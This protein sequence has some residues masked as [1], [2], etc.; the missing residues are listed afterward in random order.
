MKKRGE[1]VPLHRAMLRFSG[2]GNEG[3]LTMRGD[4]AGETSS[5]FIDGIES[6]LCDR[7]PNGLK[8]SH[9]NNLIVTKFGVSRYHASKTEQTLSVNFQF[10]ESVF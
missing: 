2:D 1:D 4:V 6:I 5:E 3:T 8:A 10:Q 7:Q 9:V